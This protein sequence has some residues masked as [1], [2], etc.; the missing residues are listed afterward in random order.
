MA[1]VTINNYF[2]SSI[3]FQFAQTAAS[4]PG[5]RFISSTS[6]QYKTTID[7]GTP[8]YSPIS[9][10]VEIPINTPLNTFVSVEIEVLR[11][12]S[13]DTILE[14][15]VTGA[16]AISTSALNIGQSMPNLTKLKT[17]IST[18]LGDLTGNISDLPTGLTYL[19]YRGSI[20]GLVTELPIGLTYLYARGTDT[21]FNLTGSFADFPST[22]E[23]IYF[24]RTGVVASAGIG[25]NIGDL[26]TGVITVNGTFDQPATIDFDNLPSTI[27]SIQLANGSQ[28]NIT[29]TGS[30]NNTP[31]N[32]VYLFIS[33][34]GTGST[35]DL[36]GD[37]AN[38]PNT[39]RYFYPGSFPTDTNTITGTIANL[40]T[41]LSRIRLEGNNTLSGDIA[42]MPSGAGIVSI[43]GNNTISGNIQSYGGTPSYLQ[44]EGNNT[45]SGDLGLIPNAFINLI[46]KGAATIN[47][48]TYPALS[49]VV[50]AGVAFDIEIV[51]NSSFT[52][53]EIDNLLIHFDAFLPITTSPGSNI[54]FNGIGAGSRT[55]ASD[56]AYNSLISKN[57]NVILN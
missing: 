28:G 40:P 46:I 48:F 9:D 20:S 11:G 16:G 1:L 50:N 22:I 18:S 43:F 14:F 21:D 7:G 52:S 42:D 57:Y 34:P 36:T 5:V 26:P 32:F 6:N 2:K 56:D 10:V 39:V 30:I 25:G 19:Y 51:G 24:Y 44:I 4:V 31:S 15:E 55:S 8:S 47:D 49:N 17:S 53:A 45:I 27:E 3:T 23:T 29:L 41:S 35:C 54:A 13:L 33:A 38:L 12:N 37:V